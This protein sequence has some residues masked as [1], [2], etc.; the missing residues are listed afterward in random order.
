MAHPE[1]PGPYCFPPLASLITGAARLMLALLEHEIGELGGT[2]AME[3]TD[4][5]AIV[6]T[7][8]GGMI[9]C[10]GGSHTA[11]GRE[12]VKA[13]SWNQVVAI[14]K[15]FAALNPYERSAI[16]GSILKIEDDNFEPG[17]KSGTK[18]QRQLYCLAISAKRYALFVMG[19]DGVPALLRRNVNSSEDHWSKHGLG[20]LL[21]PTDPESEDRNW[22]A[23]I[24]LRIIRRALGLATGPLSFE[25]APAVGRVSISSPTV[26]KAVKGFNASK[27]YSATVKPFNFLLTAHVRPFGHPT[28]ATPERF[29]LIA[30]YEPDPRR[31]L[32]MGWLDQYTGAEYRIAT[33]GEH[34][35]KRTARVKTHGE[36]VREYEYHPEPKCA[37]AGGTICGKQTVGLLRRR[38][39]RI[40]GI[41]YI[42]KESNGLEEVEA[43]LVQ[44]AESVYTEYPD[45]RRDEW[46]TKVLPAIRQIPLR[47]LQAKSGM[48]RRALMDLRAGRS[49]PRP[50]AR[51]KLL[52]LFEEYCLH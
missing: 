15:R 52:E 7:E 51:R 6:A 22:I 36:L 40:E 9:P 13:L 3:D 48:S 39:V 38:H 29:H 18:H 10:P 25:Q 17:T 5:M 30:P 45:R 43:G 44:S 35:S 4:S 31:W 33:T 27:P 20:H 49:R 8:N 2:Y 24:W 1:T 14:A 46:T 21:N 34:G 41:K 32:K 26:L 16:P 23:Q 50:E 11:N 47:E 28:G 42:G 37:G 12:V 19:S